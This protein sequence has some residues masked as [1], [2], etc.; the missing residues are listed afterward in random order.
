MAEKVI[1]APLLP[2]LDNTVKALILNKVFHHIPNVSTFLAECERVLAPGGQLLIIDPSHTPLA[3]F[4]LKHFHTEPYDD[5][6]DNWDFISNNKATDAN[7]ANTWNIF[8]RDQKKFT[9]NYPSLHLTKTQFL[10]WISYILTG[11]VSGKNL[12]PNCATKLILGLDILFS[13]LN[14]WHTYLVANDSDLS[15]G[16]TQLPH[17]DAAIE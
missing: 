10:P 17:A 16:Q 8:F 6:I 9:I 1:Q 3:R 13:P 15:S 12:I 2:L 5:K 14:G 11:G 7:Q 4:L